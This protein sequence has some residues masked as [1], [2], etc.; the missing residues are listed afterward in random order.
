MKIGILI[1]SL[2]NSAGCE[3][4]TVMLANHLIGSHKVFIISWQKHEH[5]FFPLD[6]RI[7]IFSL[8]KR[9]NANIYG[10]YFHAFFAYLRLKRR[11]KPD[12]IIDVCMASSLLSIPVNAFCKSKI[13]SWEHFNVAINWNRFTGVWAR[14]LA[15]KY[16][17][18]I[19]VLTR[20]DQE[21]YENKYNSKNLVV[22][23]NAILLNA[24]S[25][26]GV[27]NK[28]I[29]AIGRF[30]YQKGFDMLIDIWHILY[31]K[32]KDKEWSLT[33]VG[34]GEDKNKIESKV[35]ELNLQHCI[36]LRAATKD[37]ETYYCSSSIYV[38]SSRFEGLPLVLLEAKTMG[39]PIVSF[40]CPNGPRDVVRDQIDGYLIP[41]FNKE[42]FADKLLSLME[43]ET[44][45]MEFS[46]NALSDAYRYSPERFYRNWDALISKLY[47]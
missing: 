29:L 47:A 5:S 38:M 1:R 37:I 14:K 40:D 32:L 34:D 41:C 28:N 35:M 45:R 3:R 23:N 6:E 8:L 7:P 44:K 33:I 18:R 20:A 24:S 15:S 39:I 43:N 36:K 31:P 17:D 13:I 9:N 30:N 27:A 16:A 4:M 21:G 46:T 26:Y 2:N 12:L 10:Y 42:V 25:Q 22:I 11:E 19:V